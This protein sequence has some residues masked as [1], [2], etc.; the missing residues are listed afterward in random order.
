MKATDFEYDG[1]TLSSYGY[2]ICHFDSGGMNTIS[3]GSQI[4]F[5]TIPI[6]N[7][8]ERKMTS[9]SYDEVLS[10]TIQICKN[11]C[12]NKDM[13][14]S[15]D[16][17]RR[18]SRWLNRTGYKKLFLLEDDEMTNI[19]FEGY[20]NISRIEKDGI[21]VGLEL[22]FTSNR[23]FGLMKQ[24]KI[25]INASANTVYHIRDKSDVEGF[26][27]PKM[28]ITMNSSGTFTLHNAIENRTMQIK[29][30]VAGEVITVNYPVIESSIASHAI[31]NDFN[32]EFFRIANTFNQNMNDI[33]ASLSCKIEI[34]YSPYVKMSM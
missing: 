20:F 33:K 31:Q 5:N 14:I 4:T 11:P 34:E 21:T 6:Q 17:I 3:N 26:V 24:N 28:K 22:E 30:C 16:D 19:Y 2:M 25:T 27:Y 8:K 9:V 18:L 12:Y 13:A 29:N 10:T 1:L 32:W 15:V 23:P 7:G